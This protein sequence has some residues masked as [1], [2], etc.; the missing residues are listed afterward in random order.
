MNVTCDNP[1]ANWAMLKMMGAKL[2]ADDLKVTLTHVNALEIPIYVI[3]DVVHCI[4]LV[5]NCFASSREIFTSKDEKVSWTYIEKLETK[6]REEGL[7]LANKLRRRHIDWKD[8]KMKVSLAVQTLSRSVASSLELLKTKLDPEFTDVQPT[9]EFVRIFND[10][11]DIFNSKHKFGGSYVSP[12]KA[13]LTL[14]NIVMWK[15][16]FETGQL[17]I[18]SLHLQKSCDSKSQLIKSRKKLVFWA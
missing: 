16:L 3:L 6:Q 10:L 1:H 12:N 11:F 13:P 14:D 18:E 4:K 9:V 17:Y 5:R 7:H 2:D 15:T 8:N